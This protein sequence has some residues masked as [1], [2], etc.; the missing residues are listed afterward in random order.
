MNTVITCFLYI[1]NYVLSSMFI[2][3][4]SSSMVEREMR[5]QEELDDRHMDA[6]SQLLKTAFEGIS[7]RRQAPLWQ[8]HLK[9]IS[10]IYNKPWLTSIPVIECNKSNKKFHLSCMDRKKSSR[11][12][13][14]PSCT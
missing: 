6:V 8:K 4:I 13:V 11:N 14:C 9:F 5:K 10:C 3:T 1:L 12:W 2:A 7:G